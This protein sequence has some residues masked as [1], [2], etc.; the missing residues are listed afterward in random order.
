MMKQLLE[1]L[2]M[3]GA[4]EAL[5]DLIHIKDKEQFLIGLLQAEKNIREQRANKRRLSRAKFPTE[6]EWVDID[7]TLNPSIEF[8]QVERLVKS[9]FITKCQ[10]LCLMGQQGTGKTHSL[11]ALGRQ[12]CRQGISSRFYTACELVTLLEEAK[13][14]HTLSKL[15]KALAK[16]Q[17]LIIDEL[18]F[19]PFSDNGARLLFDVFATRHDEDLYFSY[20]ANFSTNTAI[21]STIL[22]VSSLIG[23]LSRCSHNIKLIFYI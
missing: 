18:G 19:V 11:I 14:N 3:S 12:L 2:K 10:N 8:G 20:M 17:L 1:S 15:M 6:K 5:P 21:F 13:A 9:D 7:P 23:T 16:P 22:A 4:L